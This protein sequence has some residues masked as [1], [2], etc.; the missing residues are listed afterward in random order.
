MP[1]DRPTRLDLELDA[2]DAA[3]AKA[4][5]AVYVELSSYAKDAGEGAKTLD[6]AKNFAR[7]MLKSARKNREFAIALVNEE[8]SQ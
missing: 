7:M 3:H 6:E 8:A 4:I 1:M 5:G 2:I